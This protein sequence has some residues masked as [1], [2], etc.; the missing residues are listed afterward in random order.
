M[1]ICIVLFWS[2]DLH[3]LVQ[4]HHFSQF[5]QV[6][7]HQLVYVYVHNMT[8]GRILLTASSRVTTSCHVCYVVASTGTIISYLIQA[9]CQL[10]IVKS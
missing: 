5:S 2:L 3:A 10:F 4:F 7:I 9:C 1:I 6:V 8:L